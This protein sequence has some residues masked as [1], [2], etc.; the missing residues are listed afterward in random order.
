MSVVTLGE[1]F[2]L[3]AVPKEGI[4]SHSAQPSGYSQGGPAFM[5]NTHSISDAPKTFWPSKQDQKEDWAAKYDQLKADYDKDKAFYDKAL[6]T[7]MEQLE[8][9]EDENS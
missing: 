8:K 7:R 4:P 6:E 2:S 5:F 9:A 3:S 1:S